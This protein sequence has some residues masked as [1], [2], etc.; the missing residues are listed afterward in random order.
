MI[1]LVFDERA[2]VTIRFDL[3]PFSDKIYKWC[4]AS[5]LR[6]LGNATTFTERSPAIFEE[7][8]TDMSRC[9]AESGRIGQC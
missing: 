6:N 8:R 2:L 3:T 9:G 5:K 4:E 1:L 7:V